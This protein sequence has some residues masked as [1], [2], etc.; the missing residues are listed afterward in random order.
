MK[1]MMKALAVLAVMIGIPA[2]SQGGPM[3]DITG[4]IYPELDFRYVQYLPNGHLHQNKPRYGNYEW[5]V[6]ES[7]HFRIYTY[8]TSE[9]LAKFFLAEAERDYEDFSRQTNM[10]AFT[11]KIQVVIYNSARDFEETNLMSSLI[12]EG[13]GGFT[14]LIRWKRVVIAFRNSVSGFNRLIRHELY[15][16]YETEFLKLTTQNILTKV[17]SLPLWF[18]EGAAEYFAHPQEEA[19]GELIMRDAYLHNYLAPVTE[20]YWMY[21]GLVYQEGEFVV[22]YLAEKYRDRGDVVSAIFREAGRSN[23]RQAFA[24]VTGQSLEDFDKELRRHIEERYHGLRVKTDVTDHARTLGRG[25]PLAARDQFFVTKTI[26][27]GRMVLLLNWT[28]GVKVHSVKLIEDGRYG[29]AALRGLGLEIAPEFG[30]NE[31]GVSFGIGNTVV[32]AIEAGGRDEIRIQHFSFDP[33]TRQF[34]LGKLEAYPVKGVRYIQYPVMVNEDE[35][36]FV[37]RDQVFAEVY[38]FYRGNNEARKLTS[39]QRSIRGLA[40]SRTRQILVASMENSANGS[41]DLAV[42]DLKT[43]EWRWLTETPENE[44]SP[45]F[46][47]DGEKML[48]VSDRGLVNNVYLYDFGAGTITPV[49]DVKIGVFYPKWFQGNGLLFA[50]LNNMRF[51][52]QIAP[53]TAGSTTVSAPKSE[54]VREASNESLIRRFQSLVPQFDSLTIMETVISQDRTKALFVVN[55]KLSLTVPR[56]NR[57]EI[58]FWLVDLSSQTAEE[59]DLKEFGKVERFGSAEFLAGTNI[60]L[61]D[62]ETEKGVYIFDWARHKAYKIAAGPSAGARLTILGF[63]F[64]DSGLIIKISPDRRY[65]AIRCGGKVA[66][67]DVVSKEF[68]WQRKLSD[69]QDI[70]I[71]ADKLIILVTAETTK[72]IEVDWTT[73]T[74]RELALRPYGLRSGRLFGWY[75]IPGANRIFLIT[76]FNARENSHQLWLVDLEKKTCVQIPCNPQVIKKAE[77]RNG[78]LAI[79]TETI[80]GTTR[81]L[82]ADQE[83]KITSTD[84]PLMDTMFKPLPATEAK[85]PLTPQVFNTDG[86][87]PP[88]QIKRPPAFP[89]PYMGMG[90]GS[91]GLGGNSVIALGIVAF[92]ELNDQAVVLD[93]YLQNWIYGFANL[94]Y[95][96]LVNGR[97]LAIEYWSSSTDR[98]KLGLG[99]SQNI[100]LDRFLNWDITLK[101]Q[102]VR[103]KRYTGMHKDDFLVREWWQTKLGTT[104]SLDTRVFDWHGPLSGNAVFTGIEA[105]MDSSSLKYQSLDLNL[106]ARHYRPFTDRSGLALRFAAGHSFGPNPTV[107]VWGG[108]QTFRGI[109]LF[110]QSG[111]SYA[112]QSTD[113]RLPILDVVGARTSIFKITVGFADIRG[114]IYNDIG[115]IWYTNKPLFEDGHREFQMQY[116]T[117]FFVNIPLMVGGDIIS[118]RYNQ[119]LWGQKGSNIWLGYNW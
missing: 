67:C 73:R 103:I 49:T 22:R 40:Y 119:G 5:R 61:Y 43:G 20:T 118:F 90:G 60:L 63:G 48:Y 52:V 58:G 57:P 95:Y 15:H 109:P 105:G 59:F 83:G 78:C 62:S 35:I 86:N 68:V 47:S 91:I 82:T 55:R 9:T 32:Y 26:I 80:F 42:G 6:W 107:F 14:E 104:F 96:D 71:V 89:K 117:G 76:N 13:L 38:I 16:R 1:K 100:F 108:N 11:E 24:T 46:S 53:L 106:D 50:S 116:S 29:N 64:R 75:P 21:G 45:E 85:T 69:V 81:T 114:G 31:H 4:T 112:L 44:D 19:Y 33:R 34:R 2:I 101:E 8:D 74:Q 72:I 98:Q 23:F 87:V 99:G 102:Y 7:K 65:L 10:N 30:F 25:I 79:E 77:I 70:A 97:S 94:S 18:A 88:H 3:D 110:S 37:G 115:D 39:L 113:L 92:D 54:A 36:A 17:S 111:N 56:G 12:P 27:L 84:Q 51:A 93:S 41:Y 28:D 66:I